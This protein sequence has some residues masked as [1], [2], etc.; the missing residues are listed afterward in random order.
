MSQLWLQK[1]RAQSFLWSCFMNEQANW[2]GNYMEYP[3]FGGK[4]MRNYGNR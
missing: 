4:Q 2:Q 1:L 3:H